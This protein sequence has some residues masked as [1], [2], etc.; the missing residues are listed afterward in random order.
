MQNRKLSEPCLKHP[1]YK[2]FW[3]LYLAGNIYTLSNHFDKAESTFS[4]LIT[5][6][7][8]EFDFY[9]CLADIYI[10][11]KQYKKALSTYD[12]I[13][14]KFG[15]DE[16][17]VIQKKNIYLQLNNKKKAESEIVKLINSYPEEIQFR[18]VL[19]D[20]YYQIGDFKKAIS[21]YKNI[22]ADNPSDG[23]SHIGLAGCY[24]SLYDIDNFFS[25]IALGFSSL[26]VGVEIKVGILIDITHDSKIINEYFDKV[27]NLSEILMKIYPDDCDVNAIYADFQ[28]NKGNIYI[29]RLALEKVLQTKKDKFT[30]WEH[31]LLIDNQLVDWNSMVK[32][33]S[34]AIEYFPN[35]PVFYFFNGLSNFQLSRFEQARS[36]LEFGYKILSKTDPLQSDYLTFLGEVY[37]K[38]D[39]KDK[40]YSYFDKLLEV[41]PENMMVMNN[42]SYYLSLDK[43]DLAKARQMSFKTIQKEPENSTYLDTYAWILFELKQYSEALTYIKKAV[44]FDLTRS[45]VIIEHYGDILYF[46]DDIKGALEQWERVKVIG[47]GSDKLDEKIASQ[48]YIE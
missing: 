26:N 39:D 17:I 10:Q 44:D 16:A 9:V 5:I 8:E 38:L 12:L 4:K 24:H 28:L 35:I 29:A 13:E 23:V 6:Q 43:R 37:Y 45:G 19:A 36:S 41:D 42:Y 14:K 20:F 21:T 7:P 47:N 46:N 1:I 22:L 48:R 34:E 40:A 30:V 27:F 33:S 31:V 2:N 3:Y 18:R 11:K 32:H 25:E 15:I